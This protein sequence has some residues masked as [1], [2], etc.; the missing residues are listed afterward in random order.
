MLR[1]VLLITILVTSAHIACSQTSN[2]RLILDAILAEMMALIDQDDTIFIELIP[3]NE[4][5]RL[6]LET[7]YLAQSNAPLLA[8][9]AEHSS[10]TIRVSIDAN[11]QLIMSGNGLYTRFLNGLLTIQHI[12]SSTQLLLQSNQF[13]FKYEDTIDVENPFDLASSWY[14]AF[15]HEQVDDRPASWVRRVLEPVLITSA[16]ATTV[17]LLYNIRSQ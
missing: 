17:Y 6:E 12:N 14:P 7:L 3:S 8:T 16:V 1:Y 2:Q 9:K 10:I 13:S 11:N 15:F 4:Q 5:A